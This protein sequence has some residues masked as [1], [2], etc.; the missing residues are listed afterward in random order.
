MSNK[1][2]QQLTVR[3][4]QSW[5][6]IWI[7]H[8]FEYG[9]SGIETTDDNHEYKT[10]QIYFTDLSIST[11]QVVQSF[12]QKYAIDERDLSVI[13][14]H[15]KEEKD[16]LLEWKK[17]FHPIYL[18]QQFIV[19]PPWE[20]PDET[21]YYK[22]IINPGNGFGSGS[23][24]STALALILLETYVNETDQSLTS[25]L[26]VGTGSGILLIASHYLGFQKMVG[27]DI[28]LP[29]IYDAQNNFRI[30]QMN[31]PALMV[32]GGPECIH[33][34][35]DI[36]ITNMMVHEIKPVR[37]FLIK[38]LKPTGAFIVS[39]FYQFQKDIILSSF[40]ELY[41]VIEMSRDEW[42]GV[43]MKRRNLI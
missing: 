13:Q 37:S 42:C 30:N 40:D 15:I 26:D 19:C 18:G 31:Y 35:F 1:S 3:I 23:H 11:T 32:C 21:N 39:G 10:L 29:S 25:I 12:C 4:N 41:S 36:V 2:Y 33:H 34:K 7:A 9:T 43:V 22:I 6:D 38:H 24:P 8:C 20:I 28:D 17:F 5:E 27:I 16:W 14:S